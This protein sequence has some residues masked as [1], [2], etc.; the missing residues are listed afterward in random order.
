[1][2]LT[3]TDS[4]PRRYDLGDIE[5]RLKADRDAEEAAR[6][7]GTLA[8]VPDPDSELARLKVENERMRSM[9]NS[10]LDARSRAREFMTIWSDPRKLPELIQEVYLTHPDIPKLRKDLND[11]AARRAARTI[12]HLAMMYEVNPLIQGMIYTWADGDKAVIEMS[13]RAY[14]EMIHRYEYMDIDGPRPMTDEERKLHGLG[15]DDRGAVVTIEDWHRVERFTK[16]GRPAPA[17]YLGIGVWRERNA[18]G[19]QDNIANGRSAQWQAEK[20]AIK[21]AARRALPFAVRKTADADIVDLEY[22]DEAGMWRLPAPVA[23]WVKR[24]DAVNRFAALLAEHDIDE[25][26]FN[27]ALGHNWRYTTLEP[28]G[29]REMFD[30]YIAA[31]VQV[32]EGQAIETPEPEPEPA[33]KKTTAKPKAAATDVTNAD[34]EPPEADH[35]PV[36]SEPKRC[37]NC[38][39]E[40]AVETGL[41]DEYCE[42]CAKHLA[43]K[44]AAKK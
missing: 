7:K 29:L 25:D 12:A 14:S 41:G 13:Y 28:S 3:T 26:A 23:E 39:I 43:N 18:R 1:M 4:G 40:A 38:G 32:V 42:T 37:A 24:P 2:A 16:H 31:R 15:P 36:G 11:E 33:P 6:P 19:K 22:D 44:E 17:P 8:T 21:D 9:I 34:P 10:A 30:T 27:D 5:A 20:N 35:P